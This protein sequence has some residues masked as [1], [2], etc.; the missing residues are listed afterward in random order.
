MVY[1]SAVIVNEKGKV[2]LMKTKDENNNVVWCFPGVYAAN[3][4]VGKKSIAEYCIN[5]LKIE[6]KINH[7]FLRDIW[8]ENFIR[9]AIDISYLKGNV[10]KENFDGIKWYSI[11]DLKNVEVWDYDKVVKDKVATCDYCKYRFNNKDKI[12]EFDKNFNNKLQE[13]IQLCETLEEN[14]GN[15]NVENLVYKNYLSHLRAMYIESNRKELRKNITL[16]NYLRVNRYTDIS[17]WIDE[18]FNA[19][20]A[21]NITFRM[22]IRETVDKYIAH[23]D[24]PDEKSEELRYL[25]KNIIGINGRMPLLKFMKALLSCTF[26]CL[27]IIGYVSGEFVPTMDYVFEEDKNALKDILREQIEEIIEEIS[28]DRQK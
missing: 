16:Q 24:M 19:E 17:E 14:R 22:V 10:C 8:T 5:E 25:C 2:L 12:H 28:N 27:L 26:V 6:T 23:Y 18:L 9:M 21:D 15:K 3:E 4:E 11:C 1:I 13:M 20:V 7:V